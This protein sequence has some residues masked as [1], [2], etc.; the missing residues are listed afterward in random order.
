MSGEKRKWP[1]K[2]INAG[3]FLYASDGQQIGACE[4]KDISGG[5]AML[6]TMA[7]E[8][9]AQFVLLLSRDGRVRR[10]CQIV[11]QTGK[12]VGVRFT[13]LNGR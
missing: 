5:G 6:V 1:R 10:H 8:L 11:W 13:E 3:G 4:V 12:H 7:D 2:S 9:P